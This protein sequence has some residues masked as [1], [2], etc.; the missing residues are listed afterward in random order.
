LKLVFNAEPFI[1]KIWF[2]LR[3]EQKGLSGGNDWAAPTISNRN[4]QVSRLFKTAFRKIE[5]Y[6][7]AY[8]KRDLTTNVSNPIANGKSMRSSSL[9]VELVNDS[10]LEVELRTAIANTDAS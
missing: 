3:L 7:F 9:T 6:W 2:A 10:D 4:G 1:E 5:E 8:F